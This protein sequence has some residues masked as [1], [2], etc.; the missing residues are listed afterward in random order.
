MRIN[1]QPY[2]N[3]KLELEAVVVEFGRK[4]DNVD[5]ICLKNIYHKSKREKLSDHVWMTF[6][7]RF[8]ELELRKGDKI[9]FQATVKTYRKGN[10]TKFYDY[11][12]CNPSKIQRI[13]SH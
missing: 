5:T 10:E 3:Q 6:G 11:Q 9:S 7:K 4:K 1:L 2:V 13:N 12:L 8:K